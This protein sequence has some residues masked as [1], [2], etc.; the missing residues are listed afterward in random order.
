MLVTVSHGT[1][2]R[3]GN[4][5]GQAV[6]A[7]AARQLGVRGVASYVE[8]CRPSL[9]DALA[10]D[11]NVPRVVVPLLLSTGVHLRRDIPAAIEHSRGSVV[12]TPGLGPHPL[13]A[14]VLVRRLLGAGARPDDGVVLVAA[15]SSQVDGLADVLRAGALLSSRWDGPVRVAT[16]AGLGPR[17]EQ[18]ASQVRRAGNG[19]LAVAPY[20]LARG[21][22]ASQAT[23]FAK[24]QRADVVADVIGPDP[25]VSQLVVRRYLEATAG[26]SLRAS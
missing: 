20:L 13:L 6:T 11:A 9:A 21:H 12:L 10:R 1:R 15:G 16:L 5:V 24:L 25:L 26:S 14:E 7:R 8:L 19:R 17:L 18:S 23:R 4:L 22:F 2:L 3:A